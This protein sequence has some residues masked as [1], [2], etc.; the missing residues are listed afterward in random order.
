[1]M[2]NFRQYVTYHVQAS[3]CSLHAKVI[4]RI[5]LFYNSLELAKIKP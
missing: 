4:K 1:M 2:G 5:E 3:K